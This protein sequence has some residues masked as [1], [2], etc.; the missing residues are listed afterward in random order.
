MAHLRFESFLFG[1]TKR[2]GD[3]VEGARAVRVSLPDAGY[4][5][6]LRRV[7]KSNCVV[8]CLTYIGHEHLYRRGD[9]NPVT[10]WT[11]LLFDP[12]VTAFVDSNLV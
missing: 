12:S 3:L 1:Q 10:L 5:I 4:W 9:N 7:K 6:L 2:R 11:L 8:K